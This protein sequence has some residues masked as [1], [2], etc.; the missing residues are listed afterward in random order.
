VLL[1][2]YAACGLMGTLG[3]H[4]MRKTFADRVY[5]LLG[6]DLLRTQHALRHRNIQ[7]T[8]RSLSFRQDDIDQAI[9]MAK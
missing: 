8:I 9:L 3:S 5:V 7:G 6:H 4:A 2:A 1:K